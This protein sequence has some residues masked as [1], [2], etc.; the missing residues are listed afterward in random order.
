MA[1]KAACNCVSNWLAG[2][3]FIMAAFAWTRFKK[4]GNVFQRGLTSNRNFENG[5]LQ[6]K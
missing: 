3:N 2:I 6:E 1:I 5:L 4:Y